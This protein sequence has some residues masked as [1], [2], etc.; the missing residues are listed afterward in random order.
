MYPSIAPN[1]KLSL[2][3]VGKN[4]YRAN[5]YTPSGGGLVPEWSITA[6]AHLEITLGDDGYIIVG[7]KADLTAKKKK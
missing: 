6:S 5:V 7:E 3:K 4:R 1:T 2:S